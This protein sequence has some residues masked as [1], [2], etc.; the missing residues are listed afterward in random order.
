MVKKLVLVE[1]I[2]Q[3]RMTYVME[4]N[5]DPQH[6]LDALTM[7]EATEEMSQEWLGETIFSHQEITEEEYF[8]IFNERNGYLETW[9]DDQKRKFIYR[10]DYSEGSVDE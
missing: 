10:V 4:V 3:Y 1:A 5:D 9:T 6:A 2:S 7:G 8:K